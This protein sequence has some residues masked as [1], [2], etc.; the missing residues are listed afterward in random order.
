[1]AETRLYTVA[2]KLHS[3]Q[4]TI[5][6]FVVIFVVNRSLCHGYNRTVLTG[7]ARSATAG[8]RPSQRPH[9][10]ARGRRCGHQL[11]SNW[12]ILGSAQSNVDWLL[13]SLMTGIG[14]NC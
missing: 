1:M 14:N 10:D 8:P 2:V 12:G 5:K 4:H 13:M 11:E 9:A 6:C 7:Q 3:K